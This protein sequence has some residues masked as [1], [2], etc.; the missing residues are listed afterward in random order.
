VCVVA[1]DWSGKLK[2]A[3]ESIWLAE[4]RDGE[5]VRLE[6]GRRRG[7]VVRHLID[8]AQAEPRLAVGLDFA[9]SFP[10]WWCMERGWRS[11]RDVWAAMAAEGEE[12]LTRCDP[13]LWGRPGKPRPYPAELGQRRTELLDAPNAK[14]VFQVGGSG[15][16][17]TGSVRGMEYLLTLAQHGFDIWPFGP[18]GWPRVVEIYPRIL[19]GPV[20]KSS[21]AVRE[22]FLRNR[23]ARQSPALLARAAGS[24]DAFDAAVSALV[25]AAHGD[26][27]TALSPTDDPQLSIEGRIWRPGQSGRGGVGV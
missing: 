7:E 25:M 21:R 6:N 24:E 22:G 20:V 16:V 11:A 15:S 13:P 8:V 19:T 26:E 14:S 27:L 18:A 4:V 10:Q 1:V 3:Q 5:L 9:F 2:R 12:L 23:F 17:G